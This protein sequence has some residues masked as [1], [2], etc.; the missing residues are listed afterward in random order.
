MSSLIPLL[1]ASVWY[2]PGWNRATVADDLAYPACT[3]FFGAANCTFEA[4]D[5]DCLWQTA[6]KNADAKAA[7]L[8]ERIAALP[9]EQREQLVLVGHSL[10]GRIVARTLAGLARRELTIQCGI[11]LAPAIPMNDPDVALMGGGSKDPAIL[12][13]NPQDITLKY[14]YAI[15]SGE[16]GPSLGTDGAPQPIAHVLEYAVSSTVTDE[17]K[18][19]KLWGQSELI[20]RICNHLANFYFE[21]LRCILEGNP[22]KEAQI[23]VPQA[24]VNVEWKVIDAG[25]WWKILDEEQGWKLEQNTITHHCRILNPNKVRTAWGSEKEMRTSF[26][27]VRRQLKH[28]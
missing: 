25:I 3:N 9:P 27:K 1:C 28:H 16:A 11:L 22:T 18:V 12:L 2:L 5:G 4:W 14:V 13:V 23:R 7:A 15:G 17:T 6:V 8:V 10:G 26:E 21:E 20:K 24:N 19:D